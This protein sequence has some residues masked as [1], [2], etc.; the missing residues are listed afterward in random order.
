MAVGAVFQARA[1]A[2]VYV[3]ILAESRLSWFEDRDDTPLA[4]SAETGG[5]GDDIRLEIRAGLP[6]PEVQAKHGLSAG[7][8][9]DTE[10]RSAA[11]R[12]GGAATPLRILVDHCSSQKLRRTLADGLTRLQS[13]RTEPLPA[14]LEQLRREL[15][16]GHWIWSQLG[17]VQCDVDRDSDDGVLRAISKLEWLL[18][19]STK[20]ND[21]WTKLYEDATELSARQGRRDRPALIAVLQTARIEVRPVGAN[22]PRH[23]ALDQS[24]ALMQQRYFTPALKRLTDLEQQLQRA[25][26]VEPKVWYRLHAQRATARFHTF[27]PVGAIDSGRRAL[28][29][30]PD[31]VEALRIL[32]LAS[33]DADQPQKAMRYATQAV[34]AHPENENAWIAMA[35]ASHALRNAPPQ[36]PAAV[37]SSRAYRL[38]QC[39]LAVMD[40]AWARVE[41]LTAELLSE[42]PREPELLLWRAQGLHNNA[43]QGAVDGDVRRRDAVR[44]LTELIDAVDDPANDITRMALVTRAMSHTALGDDAEADADM[45]TALERYPDAPDVLRVAAIRR[46]QQG[47]ASAVLKV[48]QH[49]VVDRDPGLLVLRAQALVGSDRDAARRDLD[50]GLG[51]VAPAKRDGDFRV[52]AAM[53][54][55]DLTDTALARELLDGLEVD[56]SSGQ[57]LIARGLLA[58]ADGRYGDA[59]AEFESAVAMKPALRVE[60]MASLA[61]A[62]IKAGDRDRGIGILNELGDALP[63]EVRGR[64]VRL[65]FEQGDFQRAASVIGRGLQAQPPPAWALATAASLAQRRADPESASRYFAALDARGDL[66]V[67][68]RIQL[69]LCL[70][71]LGRADEARAQLETLRTAN[72]PSGVQL[73]QIAELLS[74]TDATGQG[75]EFAYRAARMLPRDPD[76]QRAFSGMA[77]IGGRNWPAPTEVGPNTHVVLR[78][79]RGVRRTYTILTDPPIDRERNEL[80]MEAAA[81]DG[82]LGLKPGSVQVDNL[83]RGYLEERWVVERITPAAIAAGHEIAEHFHERF[84]DQPF[85]VRA[86]QFSEGAIT[87]FLPFIQ[88]MEEQRKHVT[89]VLQTYH[90]Q[91]VPLGVMAKWLSASVADLVEAFGGDPLLGEFYVEWVDPAGQQAARTAAKAATN[92]LLTRSALATAQELKLLDLLVDTYMLVA[93]TS[94]LLE[95]RTEVNTAD[96]EAAEGRERL[97]P[98]M[99]VGFAL[100]KVE[101]G[102]TTLTTRRDALHALLSWTE[103][104]VRLD[105]RPADTVGTPGSEKEELRENFGASSFDT[106][107]LPPQAGTVLYADDLGL[108][109]F[110]PADA[111][112]STVTLLDALV[113][114]GVLGG[115]ERDEYDLEMVLRRVVTIRPRPELLL[116]ALRRATLTPAQLELVFDLLAAPLLT[117]AEAASIGA[118]VIRGA[119][120]GIFQRYGTREVTR[121]ILLSMRKGFKGPQA[122]IA[123]RRATESKLQFLPNDLAEMQAVCAEATAH[124]ADIAGSRAT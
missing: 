103:T 38:A 62:I 30:Q 48:L 25:T 56:A 27:D 50:R 92:L 14:E 9:F 96:R 100:R 37:A 19:D 23:D 68:G 116:L 123:L 20:A 107:G 114:R 40:G 24:R 101:P 1:I 51:L 45:T 110:A 117:L 10:I 113:E 102:D 104:H 39:G 94:L 46:G 32:T 52:R 99:G 124:A 36:P 11:S 71:Q 47:N 111:T 54:A 74:M 65:L 22:A 34:E 84:R 57:L 31:G 82:L 87:E 28:E 44:V 98:E 16:E 7:H 29:S 21:A 90:E 73:M 81:Q 85:Y 60:L 89:N 61:F 58:V 12:A 63:D 106:L 42:G 26:D 75:I 72:H 70:V 6:N 3:H 95:L 122:P 118:A 88:S 97:V 105:P 76:V 77:I 35:E 8:E 17:I 108:R 79:D 121:L 41:E 53:V 4:V 120:E 13:G 86:F 69:T 109:R 59:E 43:E 67:D 64:Y 80:T 49:P 115:Q 66:A 93:P 33:I 18:R 112:C 78:N 2:Y 15:G 119:R 55:L 83:G 5:A 91:A